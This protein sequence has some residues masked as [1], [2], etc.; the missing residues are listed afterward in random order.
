MTDFFDTARN[1]MFHWQHKLTGAFNYACWTP[2]SIQ[3]SIFIFALSH[4][5][6]FLYKKPQLKFMGL[7]SCFWSWSK[8][9]K[10][11]RGI[12]NAYR[13]A[14]W[15][16]CSIIGLWNCSLSHC[17]QR[18]CFPIKLDSSGLWLIMKCHFFALSHQQSAA[19]SISYS[20]SERSKAWLGVIQS[21]FSHI[22]NLSVKVASLLLE[23][24]LY[25][26]YAD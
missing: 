13:I 4:L 7:P 23:T 10:F 8:I 19:V 25:C 26:L 18:K 11:D 24:F 20:R 6:I 16:V 14:D 2:V 3:E 22:I 21:L 17:L 1:R 5:S 15:W 12:A 9:D